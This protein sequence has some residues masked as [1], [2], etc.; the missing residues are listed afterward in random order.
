MIDIVG[1]SPRIGVMGK[2]LGGLICIE[3]NIYQ[4]LL[5]PK[6]RLFALRGQLASIEIA[7]GENGDII[8]CFQIADTLEQHSGILQS[9]SIVDLTGG[10]PPKM[11]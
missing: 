11:R 1:I 9:L 2:G 7:R 3:S 4:T 5:Q 10:F 6:I 8:A